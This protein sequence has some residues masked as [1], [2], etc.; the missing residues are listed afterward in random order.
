MDDSGV[1]CWAPILTFNCP[2]HSKHPCQTVKSPASLSHISSSLNCDGRY[3]VALLLCLALLL[4][5]LAGGEALLQTLRYEREAIAGGQWWRFLT[6]HLVHMDAGHALLNCTGLALL[7]ALFARSWK[8][9]QWLF[10][11]AFTMTVI[12]LGFWFI[13]TSLHWYVGASALLHGAFAFGCMAL[14]FQRDRLGQVALLVL[15][16]KL[17]WEQLHGPLPLETRHP[18]VTVSHA[19]GAAGGLLAALLLRLRSVRI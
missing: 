9:S 17:A 1:S 6:A 10:A 14:V 19:Y 15:V 16:A 7:W 8:P 11:L 2:D 3:A 4:L 5:P 18:V 12:D 13:S